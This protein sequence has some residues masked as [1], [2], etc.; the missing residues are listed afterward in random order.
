MYY[1]LRPVT[2]QQFCMALLSLNTQLYILNV[3]ELSYDYFTLLVLNYCK[4][5]Y[6]YSYLIR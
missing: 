3:N 2:A 5:C 6:K 4:D 1:G